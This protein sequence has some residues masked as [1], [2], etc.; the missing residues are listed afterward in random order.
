M[1][2]GEVE[3]VREKLERIASKDRT[4]RFEIEN[5]ILKVRSRTKDQAYKRG[6]WLK[7]RVDE[8]RDCGFE[9]VKVK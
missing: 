1:L 6:V 5:G 9:V 4:F 8:L 7:Y 3:R 2:K